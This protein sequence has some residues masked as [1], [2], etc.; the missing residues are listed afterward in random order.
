MDAAGIIA[1][2]VTISIFCLG[3]TYHAGKL[4][5]RVDSLE[6]MHRD[7]Q[8]VLDEIFRSLRRLETHSRIGDDE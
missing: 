5:S 8:R 4:S 7:M 6:R 1:V 2:G 3:V